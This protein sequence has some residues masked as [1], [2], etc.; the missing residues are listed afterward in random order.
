MPKL[1]NRAD[2]A[3]E[4]E[5]RLAEDRSLF[6]RIIRQGLAAKRWSP[7]E[8][9][10][11]ALLKAIPDLGVRNIRAYLNKDRKR[12]PDD[13]ILDV[14][15][16]FGFNEESLLHSFPG[17][18]T[19]A[20]Y[21][22]DR[23]HI[24]NEQRRLSESDQ[25]TIISCVG[26]LEVSDP[27][28]GELVISNLNK[29][30]VYR[31]FF[32]S[33]SHGPFSNDA[34]KSY[35]AFREQLRHRPI[36]ERSPRIF[37]FRID[38]GTFPYFSK[39]H[40]IVDMTSG[41]N[42]ESVYG[43]IELSRGRTVEPKQFWYAIPIRTWKEIDSHLRASHNEPVDPKLS[44]IAENSGLLSVRNEYVDWFS[45]PGHVK[46]YSDLQRSIGHEGGRCYNALVAEIGRKEFARG[47]IMYLDVG[48][49]DGRVASK[50]TKFLMSK[51][52]TEVTLVDTSQAQLALARTAFREQR[53]KLQRNVATSFEEFQTSD[54]YDLLTF[55]HSSYVI[56][57]WHIHKIHELLKPGGVAAIWMACRRQNVITAVSAAIDRELRPGTKRKTGEDVVLYSKAAGY[58]PR[59]VLSEGAVPS[60]LDSKGRPTA[61]ATKLIGFCALQT[62]PKASPAWQ[63][64]VEALATI[65]NPD[66]SHPITDAL[67]L[68]HK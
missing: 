19:Q 3:A 52:K 4:I 36:F 60:L 22:L 20:T 65:R 43:F 26:F 6:S 50:I 41:L 14:A 64:A 10:R 17:R 18:G 16:L 56:D 25:V 45:T 7:E 42:D 49:G 39:L 54:R 24:I 67:I 53:L 30:V 46:A 59:E 13:K 21:L 61:S 1:P 28:V 33:S 57:E 40:T 9:A 27:D 8:A 44:P 38:P 51:G 63:A 12:I 58:R 15:K 37:G 48:C 2:L 47:Q 55:V 35:L 11:Q 34:E 68:I 29:G 66:G 32:P 5:E 62:I 23:E 31:Y